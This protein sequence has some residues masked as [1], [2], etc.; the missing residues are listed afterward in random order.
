MNG[1]GFELVRVTV[2]EKKKRVVCDPERARCFWRKG[3]DN[4][5]WVFPQAPERV[6]SVVI[7]WKSDGPFRGF[8]ARRSSVGSHLDDLLTAGNRQTKGVFPYAVRC[9]DAAGNVVAEVDP[10]VENQADPPPDEP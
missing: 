9:L 2:D 6:T 4:V 5:C 8:S 3:P 10:D 7:E 1:K